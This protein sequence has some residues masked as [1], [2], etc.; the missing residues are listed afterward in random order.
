MPLGNIS[1]FL[2]F[3]IVTFVTEYLAIHPNAAR[4]HRF[5]FDFSHSDFATKYL[6]IYPNAARQHCLVFDIS[7][8]DFCY[9]VPRHLF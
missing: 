4:Q 8:S 2:T 3:P 7:Y 5:A 9:R 6:A 1:L